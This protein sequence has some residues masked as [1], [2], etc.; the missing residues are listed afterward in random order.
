MKITIE[1]EP[2]E[3]AACELAL[4]DGGFKI[5]AKE[6]E[7]QFA[8]SE[9]DLSRHL[10]EW[11]RICKKSRS[12]NRKTASIVPTIGQLKPPQRAEEGR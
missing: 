10:M 4:K 2:K 11:R 12:R 1:G 5:N 6:L 9:A 7:E 8:S 3:I